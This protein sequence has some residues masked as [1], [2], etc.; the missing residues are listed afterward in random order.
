MTENAG[1]MVLGRSVPTIVAANSF[2]G[3][4]CMVRVSN[5][6]LYTTIF[7]P[8]KTY[9]VESSTQMF[10]D[11]PSNNFLLDSSTFNRSWTNNGFSFSSSR[12]T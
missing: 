9:G 11:V 3:N 4:I 6:A 12:P 8:S 1:W 7:T 10:L 5:T 2:Y